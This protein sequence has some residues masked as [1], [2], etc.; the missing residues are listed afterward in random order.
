MANEQVIT[1]NHAEL[2]KFII[3]GYSVKRPL[4]IH[5]TTGIGKSQVTRQAA[6]RLAKSKGLN[7]I[8]WSNIQV[9][10]KI[11]LLSDAE[12]LDSTFIFADTRLSQMDPS[13]LRGLASLSGT[14]VDWRPTLLFKL[15]SKPEAKGIL[16][17]DEMNLACPSVQAAGYQLFLDHCVGEIRLSDNVYVMGAG[18]RVCD[19]A[20]VFEMSAPLKNRFSH[21]VLEV[22]SYDKWT[23]YAI[24]R[25]LDSRIIGFLN[26]HPSFLMADL[27]SVDTQAF[28]A[29]PTPR[30]WEF[31]SQFIQGESDTML[32]RKY[33]SA[34]VGD[35]VAAQL[36]AFIELEKKRVDIK[37]LLANPENVKQYDK[38]P[39]VQWVIISAVSEMYRADEKLL[40]KV[41]EMAVHLNPDFAVYLLR[42]ARKTGGQKFMNQLK[43]HGRYI[44]IVAKYAKY[45][46]D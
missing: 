6:M 35:A 44:E 28:D 26:L 10:N 42:I 45:L 5:G 40:S 19:T 36:M 8:E 29:F 20:S 2:E 11:A 7:F 38:E 27:S 23:D 17:F 41:M 37:A 1:V 14:Y 15:L 34:N 22:P 16:F 3:K 43:K 25:G 24:D 4:F 9:E 39:D 18:N 33:S 30:S 21:I 12:T 13:D 46:L 32:I 31:C